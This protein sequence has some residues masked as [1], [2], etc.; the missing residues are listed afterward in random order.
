MNYSEAIDYIENFT[1]SKTK[2]GL[3]RTKELLDRLGN[4][5]MDLK[6][7]HVAGSNGKGS[8][9]CMIEYILRCAGY[10]TGFY[11]SPYVEDFRESFQISG[12]M[13]SEEDLCRI[14]E[15]VKKAAD[16]MEDHPSQFEIKTAIAFQY[17]KEKNVDIVI[18]E[19]GLGGEYDSTN[20]IPAPLVAVITNIGLEH[21]EYLGHSLIEI[22]YTKAGII[23]PGCEVVTYNNKLEV[24]QILKDVCEKRGCKFHRTFRADIKP[25]FRSINGQQFIW[26]HDGQ[27]HEYK[28]SLLGDH[29]LGNA[30]VALTTISILKEKGFD[31]KEEDIKRA[32]ATVKWPV[33]FEVISKDPLFIMDGGHNPQCAQAMAHMLN[34]YLPYKKFSFILGIL[35]DK[36]YSSMIDYIAPFGEEFFCLTPD[37]SRALPAEDL[38]DIF[39]RRKKKAV[40]CASAEEA[41]KLALL[42][43]R[44]VISFG[45]LYMSGEVRSIVKKRFG[46][47]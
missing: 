36:D 39:K 32:L 30:A 1:W 44:P 31:V 13:I 18:L 38:A 22:A 40:A 15:T 46:V 47:K 11:L 3:D 19:V 26:K 2:L 5:H 27:E 29:Q 9:C 12:E 16:Q 17:F 43:H 34:E 23:K 8:T 7:V 10:K 20:V 28:L 6:Y 35:A 42:S 4:P 33:R 37:N 21:T 24:L 14:T 45:S 41:V 25:E